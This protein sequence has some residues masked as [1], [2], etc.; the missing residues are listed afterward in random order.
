MTELAYIWG[1]SQQVAAQ[2][3]AYVDA[4]VDWIS[5]VDYLPIVSDPAEGAA[6]L[7]RTI[8]VCTILKGLEVSAP[9]GVRTAVE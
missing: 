4:G 6:S 5:P 8:D 2:L 1:N 7:G 3:Q 9:A